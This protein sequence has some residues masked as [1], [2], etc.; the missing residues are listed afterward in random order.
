MADDLTT[1]QETVTAKFFQV[2]LD[3]NWDPSDEN[4]E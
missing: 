4:Y 2:F 1:K 3:N